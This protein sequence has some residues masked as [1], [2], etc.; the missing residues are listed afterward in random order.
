MSSFD[1][2]LS[3]PSVDNPPSSHVMLDSGATGTFVSS[4]DAVHLRHPTPTSTG[5][6]VL[7]A[8][9]DVMSSS[10][11]GVLPLSARL[12]TKAQ[13]AFVL[14]G[15]QTG[16]LVS[17]AQL[18]DDDC[19]AIFTKYDV[20]VLKNDTVIITGVRTPNGL[21]AIPIDAAHQVNGILRLDKS[22]AELAIY[23][24][25]TLGSPAVSTL[26]RA[27]R[28]GHLSTFPGLTTNLIS[29]YLSKSI[30]TTLGHQDQEAKNIRSTRSLT[31][32]PI[33]VS[34]SDVDIAPPFEPRSH[35]IFI[36][37]LDN[38]PILKS[39]SHQKV[40]NGNFV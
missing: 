4:S 15:L 38:Q 7:S 26:L 30:A 18:C 27:I 35:Q 6:T 28:R 9:G 25:T 5:P 11:H 16:T 29:K 34:D 14:D 39:C 19:I 31:L 12:S 37:V 22:H 1:S 40:G 21:W 2:V 17:L 24:H 23:H 33:A 3:L 20:Q 10:L 36:A 32:P 8:S 13:S